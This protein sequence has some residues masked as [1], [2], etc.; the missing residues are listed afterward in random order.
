MLTWHDPTPMAPKKKQ[1]KKNSA[2]KS[3]AVATTV[4]PR[5]GITKSP[6]RSEFDSGS[7]D[8]S[9][10]SLISDTSDDDSDVP[11]LKKAKDKAKDV[12]SSAKKGNVGYPELA[13]EFAKTIIKTQ[14][15]CR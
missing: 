7:D 9:L 14:A 10:P 6:N 13:K 5:A 8:G 12:S 15:C 3:D 4:S 1:I 2:A 11:Q